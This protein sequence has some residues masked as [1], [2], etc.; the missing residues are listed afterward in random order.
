ME[1]ILVVDLWMKNNEKVPS[2][3]QLKDK[4]GDYHL[5]KKYKTNVIYDGKNFL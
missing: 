2:P 5:L 1:K 4:N 3:I